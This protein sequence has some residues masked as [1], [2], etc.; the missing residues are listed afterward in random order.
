MR[1]LKKAKESQSSTRGL[2]QLGYAVLPKSLK[3]L[4]RVPKSPRSEGGT[5]IKEVSPSKRLRHSINAGTYMK[6]LTKKQKQ[7]HISYMIVRA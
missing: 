2:Q 1:K 4:T 5:L 7:P 3:A 6:A